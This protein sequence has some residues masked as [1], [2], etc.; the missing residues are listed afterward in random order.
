MTQLKELEN[1]KILIIGMQREGMSTLSFVLKNI[2]CK[3]IGV[4][5]IEQKKIKEEGIVSHFGKKYLEAVKNYDVIIKS[6][7]IPI[8]SICLKKGQIITSQ[9][10]LFLSNC[11]AKIIGITGTKGKST[12]SKILYNILK[13]VNKRSFLV[14]NIGI[15][16]LDY[17][18]KEREDDYFVYEL[19]SF[20]LQTIKKSPHI[21]IFLNIYPDHLD[22]HKTFK[23]YIMAKTN[24][25]KFQTINDFLIYNVEDPIVSKIALKSKAK[26]IKFKES[27]KYNNTRNSFDSILKVADLLK[28]DEDIVRK[29]ILNFKNL[30]HRT[31]Y[32]GVYKNIHF[33]NDSAATIPEATAMAVKNIKNIQT[34]I[35]G[36]SE[37]G[38]DAKKLV[39]AI[40]ESNI[41]NI[42]ILGET[43][44]S[45][46]EG[47]C[48][49]D[50]SIYNSFSMKDAVK[51]CY[52]YTNKNMS[53][54]L[55][56]GFASFN[57]FKDY[58]ERGD[59]FKKEVLKNK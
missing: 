49:I 3:K 40:K 30:P 55:S 51:K 20:Q 7:G 17:L 53:C 31:E 36:G 39:N 38:G 42:I 37:K 57:M 45:I 5:D 52:E 59:L 11:R 21:A 4:A 41:E 27:K 1:K 46:K 9:S 56:P 6:P 34:I 43:P 23:E 47:I 44:P 15:P 12:T 14:G 32:I 48:N 35:I 54:I 58:K 8:S 24:I 18:K 33:Y 10:D 29:T 22:Y 13:K 28:I 50:K 26:K 2:H 16:S 25:T 19:S